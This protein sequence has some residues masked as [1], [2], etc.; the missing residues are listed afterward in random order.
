[1]LY[2][3]NEL[4]CQDRASTWRDEIRRPR[5]EPFLSVRWR[6]GMVQRS[7]QVAFVAVVFFSCSTLAVIWQ[8]EQALGYDSQKHLMSEQRRFRDDLAGLLAIITITAA[9]GDRRRCRS[10]KINDEIQSTGICNTSR[11]PPNVS[12]NDGVLAF[13]MQACS[14]EAHPGC[15]A[16]PPHPHGTHSALYHAVSTKRRG[17]TAP[18]D[19]PSSLTYTRIPNRQ[20]VSGYAEERREKD[21]K[22]KRA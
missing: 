3:D 13:F 8:V 22:K 21:K 20:V 14:L 10:E 2:S 5:R 6:C 1:M 9:V 18:A 12:K 7:V 19:P 15:S 4:A 17:G 11:T 16:L